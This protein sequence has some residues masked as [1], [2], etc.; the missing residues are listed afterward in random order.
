MDRNTVLRHSKSIRL[1]KQ[2]L[3][4]FTELI[5]EFCT[6]KGHPEHTSIIIQ[7]LQQPVYG[8]TIIDKTLE[9][10]E[11]EYHIIKL[12]KFL[13]KDFKLKQLINIY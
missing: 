10:F 5:A 12:E 6:I 4:D 13:D 11:K 7:L 9:Y 2:V 1:N 3:P 8:S